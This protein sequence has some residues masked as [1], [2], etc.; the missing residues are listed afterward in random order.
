MGQHPQDD[1]LGRV[2]LTRLLAHRASSDFDRPGPG[3]RPGCPPAQ[4]DVQPPAV[5]FVL[6][7]D[8][9]DAFGAVVVVGTGSVCAAP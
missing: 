4:P 6:E 5:D 2:Q 3:V 7:P 1:D 9:I 8:L